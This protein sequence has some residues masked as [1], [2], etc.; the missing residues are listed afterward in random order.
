MALKE[1]KICYALY[2]DELYSGNGD[3]CHDCRMKLEGTYGR[4]HNYLRDHEHQSKIDIQ[5]LAEDTETDP[6]DMQL[7]LELGWLERD[8]Q[9]YSGTI[10]DRQ[11]LAAEFAHELDVMIEQ[12]KARI[13]SGAHYR[14]KYRR[15]RK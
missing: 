1:C 15:K 10:S 2:D 14:Y 5:K 13:Y 12:K 3:V 7:L 8:I 4:I 9:T 11:A 6:E